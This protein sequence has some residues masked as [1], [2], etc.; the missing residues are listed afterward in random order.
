MR[1][2]WAWA[3]HR[4]S[5]SKCRKA[6]RP[7]VFPRG[8]EEREGGQLGVSSRQW[9]VLLGLRPQATTVPQGPYRSHPR[10]KFWSCWA[11]IPQRQRERAESGRESRMPAR[12]PSTVRDTYPCTYRGCTPNSPSVNR[13][14]GSFRKK[15]FNRLLMTF[16][17]CHLCCGERRR[18]SEPGEGDAPGVGRPKPGQA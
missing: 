9:G 14:S 2:P 3:Q 5:S 6:T 18:H 1:Y 7:K 8:N 11:V 13:G 16:R 12:S 4:G 17:S 10:T 15:D